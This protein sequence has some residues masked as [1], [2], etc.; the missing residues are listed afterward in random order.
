MQNTVRLKLNLIRINSFWQIE[1]FLKNQV[2]IYLKDYPI[3]NTSDSFCV[4][5]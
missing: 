1:A 4:Y 2:F 3:H 5:I